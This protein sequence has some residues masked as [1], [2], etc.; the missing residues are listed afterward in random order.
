MSRRGP[1]GGTRIARR[2]GSLAPAALAGVLALSLAACGSATTSPGASGPAGSAAAP[3]ATA[4]LASPAAPVAYADTLRVGWGR[5]EW[6]S[7]Y[8]APT[9]WAIYADGPR[10]TVGSVVYGG[11]Y[12]YDATLDAAPDLA[13]G[14]CVPQADPKVIRCRLIETTFQDGSP[15]TADDVAF[16]FDLGMAMRNQGLLDVV[17]NTADVRVADPRTVEFTLSTVDPG[18]LTGTLADVP[19]LSRHVVEA[20]YADFL[21]QARGLAPKDLAALADEIDK[22]TGSSP[23]VC[24]QAMQDRVAALYAAVPGMTQGNYPEDFRAA[25]GS[26]DP[27]AY[28]AASSLGIRMAVQALE[29]TGLD[30]LANGF[31]LTTA[32]THPVGTGP[33]AFVSE[34]ADL[35]RVEA[36]PGYHGEPA[37]T[38]Y[39]DFVPAKGDGSDVAGGTIDL[40]QLPYADNVLA[41]LGPSFRAADDE[42][43]AR[44]GTSFRPGY[45]YLG[46]NVRPGRPFADLALRQALQRCIDLPRDV[47]AVTRGTGTAIYGPVTPGTWAYDP[48]VARPS[49]DVAAARAL[50]E[51]AGWKPGADGV[52]AK[53]GTRLAASILVRSEREDRITFADLVAKQARDCGMDL[54]TLPRDWDT[55]NSALVYPVEIPGTKAP[56]DLWIGA[57]GVSTDP[58][59][60]DMFTS[61]NVVDKEHPDA[62]NVGGFSD[63]VVDRL[64]NEA[65]AT[66]DHAR[67]AT[68]Y[69][70]V[71]EE[72]ASQLPYIFLWNFVGYDAVRSAVGTTGGPLDVSQP[73]WAWAPERLVVRA[74]P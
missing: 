10:I 34:S 63:P 22:G 58:S 30:A 36:W 27:C 44:L 28:L 14:P 23:P 1:Y 66:Y 47:D 45:F 42:G 17:G 31:W 50:I 68:L 5:E 2:P 18:F 67:R 73:Y 65:T 40:Y 48:S 3:T 20:A 11:L 9:F 13:D 62:G 53:D 16:T 55:Y 74:N 56:L 7:G 21:R 37:A 49:R 15:L 38:R 64:V 41:S 70:Q 72:L 19:I 4:A 71:Q 24:S 8:R 59:D 32:S 35:I 25:N 29:A 54:E 39:I 33:Y 69:R 46:F 61:A 52:Y 57:W 12:R 51:A 26:F 60:L 6:F 43:S